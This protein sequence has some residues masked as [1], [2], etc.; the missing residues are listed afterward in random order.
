LSPEKPGISLKNIAYA[1]YAVNKHT[2]QLI[3]SHKICD[4]DGFAA[5]IS[6][7]S[8]AIHG[9]DV[10]VGDIETRVALHNGANIIAADQHRQAP[11]EDLHHAG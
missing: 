5:A 4:Y 11:V 8:P 2:G 6:R 7:N 1:Q 10:I 9:N 3:W